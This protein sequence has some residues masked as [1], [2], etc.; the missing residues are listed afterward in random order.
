MD[1]TAALLSAPG[2]AA[3]GVDV[4]ALAA[5]PVEV[6]PAVAASGVAAAACAPPGVPGEDDEGSGMPP[7]ARS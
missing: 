1:D 3:A 6:G 4:E 7:S 5:S 2:V